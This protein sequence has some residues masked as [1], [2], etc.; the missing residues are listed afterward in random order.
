MELWNPGQHDVLH[1]LRLGRRWLS[2]F[3]TWRRNG[4]WGEEEQNA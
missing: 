4:A 2:H 1:V 3:E